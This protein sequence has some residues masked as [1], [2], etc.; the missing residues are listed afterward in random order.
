MCESSL[1]GP[2]M[3]GCLSSLLRVTS[4]Y[5]LLEWIKKTEFNLTPPRHIGGGCL[6]KVPWHIIYGLIK[7]HRNLIPDSNQLTWRIRVGCLFKAPTCSYQII[8]WWYVLIVKAFSTLMLM[9]LE[10]IP[11]PGHEETAQVA[12]TVLFCKNDWWFLAF[13]LRAYQAHDNLITNI[14]RK[15]C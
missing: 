6:L 13:K 10:H 1:P 2:S 14:H 5:S 8:I 15:G 12:W 7:S 4:P 11:T 9:I 3:C